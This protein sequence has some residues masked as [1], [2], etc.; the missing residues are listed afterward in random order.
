MVRR[1]HGPE[2]GTL[3]RA[4]RLTTILGA[5]LTWGLA[6]GWTYPPMGP[7]GGP[8]QGTP[9]GPYQVGP[10][11]PHPGAAQAP[12]PGAPQTPFLGAAPSAYPQAP[13]QGPQGGYQ[14]APQVPYPAA[15][16]QFRPVQPDNSRGVPPGYQPPAAQTPGYQPPALAPSYQ[17]PARVPSY[18]PPAG[19]MPSYQP[20]YQGVWPTAPSGYAPQQA[21]QR[22]TKQ[23]RLEWTLNETQPY[24]Q[25]NLL[26]RLRLVS[27]DGLTTADP[28]LPANGDALMQRLAGPT[29]ST[30]AAGGNGQRE[31]ITEFV[32]TLT[33][34]RSGNLELPPPKVT[35]TRPGAYGGS[36]RYEA[37]AAKP[38]RLQVRPSMASVRPWLPLRSLTLNASFDHGEQLRPGQPVT[39]ALELTAVG[40]HAAQLPNLEDQLVSPDFRVYREQSL[41]DTSLSP[42]GRQMIGTRTEYYTLVPQS[43][44]VLRLP[45]IEVPWWNVETGT[46]QVATLPIRTL[47]IGGGSGPFNLPAS[48]T[49]EGAGWGK[50]WLPLGAVLLVLTGYWAGVFYRGRGA[51]SESAPAMM[52]RLRSGVADISRIAGQQ[53]RRALLRLHPAPVAA[54]LQ[55]VVFGLLPDSSRF[56][57]VARH[58]SQA[59]TPVLWCER[60][61]RAARRYLRAGPPGSL[62]STTERIL[63]LRP[64]A[65][66]TKITRLMEQLDAALYGRQ[67]IDFPR[68]KL[69]FMRQVGRIHALLR[70]RR[71]QR[72]IHRAQLPALNPRPA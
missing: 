58:A 13:Y 5:A 12:Y 17:P 40:A 69:E 28:D 4:I 41:T 29:S 62:P 45:Q 39:L 54:S 10:Q 38:V 36:E 15:P 6:S 63:A 34:L 24:V 22:Q 1:S 2:R 19:Q 59:D 7:Y 35:G 48:L 56:L 50:V 44:G 60:F 52:V 14:P 55:G 32:L 25:Q 37:V 21:P 47:R 3:S 42:D 49:A 9:Q 20:G 8:A 64:R 68:W 66:R 71:T 18:Q 67:D 33:P 23:P 70:T 16:Y 65:D 72:R 46:R 57:M 31:V 61:E 30:R 53:T 27:A 51:P 11:A 43:A 26:L